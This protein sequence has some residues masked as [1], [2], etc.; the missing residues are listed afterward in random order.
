MECFPYKKYQ[1]PKA[2]PL[3]FAYSKAEI[4]NGGV[5]DGGGLGSI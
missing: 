4:I 3:S 2:Y 5:I 1:W